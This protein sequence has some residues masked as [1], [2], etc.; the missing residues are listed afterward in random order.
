M[1]VVDTS[2]V[3]NGLLGS[4]AAGAVLAERHLCVPHL[5]DSE[6]THTLRRL[7]AAGRLPEASGR[8]AL[9]HWLG[10]GVDRY[11]AAPL[12]LRVW[13][14]RDNLAA[15]DATYVALAEALGVRLVTADVRLANAPGARCDVDIVTDEG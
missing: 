1:I 14:L 7:V 6:V 9:E 5:T 8:A 11:S 12:L 2:I 4:K 3:V 13:E 15:Y 10:M